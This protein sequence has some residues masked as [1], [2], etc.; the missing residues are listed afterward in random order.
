MTREFLLK[1]PCT[2]CSRQVA[3]KCAT[4]GII[5]RDEN[6]LCACSHGRAEIAKYA[7]MG[8][9]RWLTLSAAPHARANRMMCRKLDPML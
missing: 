1:Q 3:T 4:F 6:G 5:A 8:H 7:R 9:E 2:S